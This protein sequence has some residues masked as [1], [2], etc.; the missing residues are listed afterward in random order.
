MQI[1]A[2][3]SI[4]DFSMVCETEHKAPKPLS[5]WPQH[6]GHPHQSMASRGHCKRRL[7]LGGG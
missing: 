1:R 2:T 3:K 5:S 7:I 4:K 6:D